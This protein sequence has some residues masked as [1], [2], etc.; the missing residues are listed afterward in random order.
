MVDGI[1]MG[2]PLVLIDTRLLFKTSDRVISTSIP[3]LGFEQFRFAV[4]GYAYDHFSIT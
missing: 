4:S 1:H 3:V 2:E